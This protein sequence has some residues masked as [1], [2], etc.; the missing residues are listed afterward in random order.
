MQTLDNTNREALIEEL[1]IHKAEFS[2]LRDE[3]L[4]WLDAQKQYLNLSLVAIGAGLGFASNIVQQKTFI[5]FLLFPFVFHVLLWEMMNSRRLI[6]QLSTYLVGTLIPRVNIILDRLGSDREEVSALGWEIHVRTKSFSTS[7]ILL[8]SLTPSLHWVPILAVGA[9]IIS[10]AT[11]TINQGY[12]PSIGEVALIILNLV[13]LIF[14][15]VRNALSARDITQQ[16][17][18]WRIT[19]NAPIAIQPKSAK[20]R[21]AK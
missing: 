11:L 15:A 3:I 19:K 20:S 13:L 4:H 17:Q 6:D 21:K 12:T 16:S 5:V 1:N 7:E 2:A 9:L 8:S 14:A 18:R 10:Y